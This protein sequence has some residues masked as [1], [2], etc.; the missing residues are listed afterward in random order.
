MEYSVSPREIQ[1]VVKKVLS[2]G[3]IHSRRELVD[4]IHKIFGDTS[5]S[6]GQIAGTLRTML[7]KESMYYSPRRGQ[8]QEKISQ[9]EYQDTGSE[10]LEHV[11]DRAI[12][13]AVDILKQRINSI[14]ILEMTIQ[15][16]EDVKRLG[17]VIESLDQIKEAFKRQ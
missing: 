7:L 10:I 1:D 17:P 16:L 4:E 3:K 15:E 2:D 14:D 12:N 9:K 6:E 11:V 5:V 8:Y 13:A